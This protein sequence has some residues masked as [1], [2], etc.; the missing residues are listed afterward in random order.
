MDACMPAELCKQVYN[1]CAARRLPFC[2]L[3]IVVPVG[4]THMLDRATGALCGPA[5]LARLGTSS[6]LVAMA[7]C[8]STAGMEVSSS[9]RQAAACVLR[10][11][12]QAML[13]GNRGVRA[14]ELPCM[15]VLGS[16][17]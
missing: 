10:R 16:L 6:V 11:A 8:R 7:L 13:P 14:L 1:T 12:W 5:T 9:S 17:G 4:S 3:S 15:Q 2:I